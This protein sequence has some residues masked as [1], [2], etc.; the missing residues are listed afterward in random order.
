LVG[1]FLMLSGLLTNAALCSNSFY[2]YVFIGQIFF[3]AAALIGM[4]SS[5]KK[6]FLFSV[7]A[8]FVFLNFAVLRGLWYYFKSPTAAGWQTASSVKN[9]TASHV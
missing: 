2:R 8:G 7:P 1:P 4:F 5:R 9:E 3:Y 6:I